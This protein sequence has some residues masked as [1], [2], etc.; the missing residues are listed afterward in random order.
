[1]S[2]DAFMHE[3]EV[4]SL[5]RKYDLEA[6]PVVNARGKLV[7]RITI[8]DVV[9][10]LTEMAEEERQI[11]AGISSDVEEDDSVWDLSKA[12][13]PLAYNRY[14]RRISWSPVYGTVQRGY[15][16]DP[17]SGIFHTPDNCNGG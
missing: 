1:M 2:V 17:G 4:V 6:V 5:M 12:R 15:R 14:G 9:D 16:V 13:L 3:E 8:D 7:G 11:M 10:V